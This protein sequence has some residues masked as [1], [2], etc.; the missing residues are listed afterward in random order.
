V[1]EW[2]KGNEYHI[3]SL[4]CE[5]NDIY[6]KQLLPYMLKDTFNFGISFQIQVYSTY[7]VRKLLETYIGP[8]ESE[9]CILPINVLC[10]VYGILVPLTP[11]YFDYTC[12]W[13]KYFQLLLC[14]SN[15]PDVERDY[16]LLLRT[17]FYR[18]TP[19]CMVDYMEKYSNRKTYCRYL[20]PN[21]EWRE[22]WATYTTFALNVDRIP[23]ELRVMLRSYL[24]G[25]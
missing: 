15:I 11:H 12:G 24:L 6:C 2:M 14:R 22:I 17:I 25:K 3:L 13:D 18:D 23:K 20:V 19:Y 7:T 8:S 9:Y 1:I 4:A 10:D 5:D 16:I 21:K